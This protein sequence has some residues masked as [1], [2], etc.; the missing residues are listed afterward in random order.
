MVL[1]RILYMEVLTSPMNVKKKKIVLYRLN[2][3]K[4]TPELETLSK[5]SE[6]P[7]LDSWLLILGCN[8]ISVAFHK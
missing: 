1:A 7:F 8:F 2:H 6:G 3:I 5:G 4:L